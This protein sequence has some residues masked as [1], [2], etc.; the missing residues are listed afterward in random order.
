[1]LSEQRVPAAAVASWE[2]QQLQQLHQLLQQLHQLL[3][4]CQ[5]LRLFPP[6]WSPASGS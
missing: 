6:D 3:P 1:M 5:L 4:V 2:T